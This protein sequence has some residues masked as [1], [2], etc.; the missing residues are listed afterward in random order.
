MTNGKIVATERQLVIEIEGVPPCSIRP[1]IHAERNSILWWFGKGRINGTEAYI[2]NPEALS[3]TQ[4][5]SH[6]RSQ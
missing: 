4:Y 5:I 6:A 2:K 1:M 3:S